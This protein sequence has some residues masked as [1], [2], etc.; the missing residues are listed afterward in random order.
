MTEYELDKLCQ[1]IDCDCQCMKCPYFAK[2]QRTELGLDE[3]DDD[4]DVYFDDEGY[5]EQPYEFTH[6]YL[7][8][9][10]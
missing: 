9:I 2:Y 5:D 4:D 8:D 6:E 3:C 1:S 7:S 10:F